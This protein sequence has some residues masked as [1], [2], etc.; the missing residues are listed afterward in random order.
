MLSHQRATLV[1]YPSCVPTFTKIITDRH[2]TGLEVTWYTLTINDV[3]DVEIS[4]M[5]NCQGVIST[6]TSPRETKHT[7]MV[8]RR[9]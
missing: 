2:R 6:D 3:A 8:L 7:T 5:Y 1:T 4:A 9:E